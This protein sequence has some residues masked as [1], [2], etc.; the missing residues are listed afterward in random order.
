MVLNS[1]LVKTMQEPAKLNPQIKIRVFPSSIIDLKL[2][3]LLNLRGHRL[4]LGINNTIED[5]FLCVKQ[6]VK[7]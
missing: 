2:E 3:K 5:K 6:I 1:I 7:L 4:V